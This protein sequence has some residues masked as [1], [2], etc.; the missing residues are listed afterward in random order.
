MS[1]LGICNRH[2]YVSGTSC[3][4]CGDA[5]DV[6]LASG[7]RTQLS[8][9]LSGALRHFP[10]DAGLVLDERGWTTFDSVVDVVTDRYDWATREHVEAVVLTDPKGRFERDTGSE[11][12]YAAGRIRAAYGHSVDVNLDPGE[13][14]VPDT[15]Y[16]GTAPRHVDAI[17]AEG[18]KPMSRQK[19][20]LSGTRESALSVGER[21]ADD[22]VLLV[23]DAR[24]LQAD[25]QRILKRG[26]DVYTT[27][28][29]SAEYLEPVEPDDVGGSVS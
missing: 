27:D 15:L 10:D 5:V 2:G 8:K 11:D 21:H 23:V 19:V 29:I 4:D 6:V 20:H 25:G 9:F 1:N 7:R 28:R 14:P 26:E 12:S 18:L 16:H 24:R 13:T 3:P 17:L 22:P